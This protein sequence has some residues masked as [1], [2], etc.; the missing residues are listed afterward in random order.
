MRGVVLDCADWHHTAFKVCAYKFKEAG[1][2]VAA[3]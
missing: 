1:R 2:D 3:P